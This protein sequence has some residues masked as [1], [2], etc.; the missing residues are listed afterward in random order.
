M[1]RV[2]LIMPDDDKARFVNQARREGMS[3]SAWM[4]EAA[5]ER[6]ESRQSVKP[7]ES[8][9]DILEFFRECAALEGPDSEPDW[10]ENLRVMNESRGRG[11][12]AT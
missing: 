1:A 10:E 4:R 2:Q 3:L 11:V 7:F 8:P 5:R 12:S 9:E 6:F